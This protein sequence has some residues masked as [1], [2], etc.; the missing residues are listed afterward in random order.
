MTVLCNLNERQTGP[1]VHS[2]L[3]VA[4]IEW[5]NGL[6]LHSRLVI[7]MVASTDQLD[8]LLEHC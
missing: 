1:G 7:P 4:N 5:L 6:L 3:L 8:G 2:R